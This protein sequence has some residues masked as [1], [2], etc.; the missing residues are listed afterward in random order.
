ML[1]VLLA[2][3]A[4]PLV[5]SALASVFIATSVGWVYFGRTHTYHVE[6]PSQSS[7]SIVVFAVVM[8]VVA[9]AT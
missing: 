5:L 1:E 6:L 2:S 7:L 3:L 4:L 9:G 8:G